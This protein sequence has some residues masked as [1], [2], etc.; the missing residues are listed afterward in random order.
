MGGGAAKSDTCKHSDIVQSTSASHPPP[1][2]MANA[3]QELSS[4]QT[5]G[6]HRGRTSPP[7]GS[8]GLHHKNRSPTDTLSYSNYRYM[9]HLSTFILYTYSHS[10]KWDSVEQ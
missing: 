7:Q 4:R 6:G 10:H 1:S 9:L 8:F 3:T 5:A 2:H